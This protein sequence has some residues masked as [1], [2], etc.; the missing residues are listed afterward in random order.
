MGENP[1]PGQSYYSGATGAGTANFVGLRTI[2]TYTCPSDPS[3]PKG[4]YTD[5]LFNYQWAT[6]SYA[7]NFLIFGVVNNPVQYDT[8][9]SWQGCEQH[10]GVVHG[11][12]V[13]HHPVR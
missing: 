7:G 8:M 10:T 5:V 4:T 6:T 2:K 9:L 3:A 1:G 13:Q 12:H 11:R